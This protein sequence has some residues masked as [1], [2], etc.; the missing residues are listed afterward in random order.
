MRV[1]NNN[2]TNVSYYQIFTGRDLNTNSVLIVI[3]FI[4]FYSSK[5]ISLL[6]TNI[7]NVKFFLQD[8]FLIVKLFYVKISFHKFIY[9]EGNLLG[10]KSEV[11]CE[12]PASIFSAIFYTTIKFRNSTEYGNNFSLNS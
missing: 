2:F 10:L 6:S 5:F 9:S 12:W 4:I 8:E 7:L 11:V 1:T 3:I